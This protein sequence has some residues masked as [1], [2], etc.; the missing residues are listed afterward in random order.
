LAIL[1]IQIQ[2]MRKECWRNLQELWDIYSLGNVLF[3][4][5]GYILLCLE[6]SI[7]EL[8]WIELNWIYL[9]SVNPVQADTIGYGTSQVQISV[10][11]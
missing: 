5:V 6:V 7:I 11:T 4:A 9:H 3:H 1:M 10:Y 8:N 2:K